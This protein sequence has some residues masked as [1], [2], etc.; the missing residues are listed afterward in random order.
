MNS[1]AKTAARP[2]GFRRL[3]IVISGLWLLVFPVAY[4]AGLAFYPSRLTTVLRHLYT[5]SP[6]QPAAPGEPGHEFGFIPEFPSLNPAALIGLSLLPLVIGW[7]FL[8]LLPLSFRW[9]ALVSIEKREMPNHTMQPT[10]STVLGFAQ[11]RLTISLAF[12][13]SPLRCNFRVFATT[14]SISSRCPASLVRFASSRSRT[15][16][17]KLFNASRGLSLSR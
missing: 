16:A 15:P 2:S 7:L 3:G 1:V 10:R 12:F 13:R 17:V 4:F 8:W 14:P 6:G 9:I 11:G 5:W